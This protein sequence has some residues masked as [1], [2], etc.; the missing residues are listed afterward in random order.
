MAKG[1]ALARW[2]GVAAAA[3]ALLPGAAARAAPPAAGADARAALLAAIAAGAADATRRCRRF[4]A[5]DRAGRRRGV[6]GA[7]RH[8]A[9]GLVRQAEAFAAPA[10]AAAPEARVAPAPG[11]ARAEVGAGRVAQLL[12]RGVLGGGRLWLS[13][14]VAPAAEADV[15]EIYPPFRLELEAGAARA[16][17]VEAGSDAEFRAANAR[18]AEAQAAPRNRYQQQYLETTGRAGDLR[19]S[20]IPATRTAEMSSQIDAAEAND[21]CVGPASERAGTAEAC[22]GCPNAAACASGAG[23]A[24]P[25]DPTP[26]LVRDRLAGVKHVLL[27]LSGK[28]GVGKSTMSC[29]LALAPRGYDAGL[30]DIDICGPS[31][32]RMM[33]LRGRGVHQS[34]SGWSPVYVDSPGGELGVMSVG[35]M[36]PED[37]N[38]IIW[39]GPRKNGLI[40]QFLTEY[41]KLATPPGARRDDAQEVAMQDVRKELN[42]CAKT[43]IP[44]LGVVGNMCR[45]RVPLSSLEFVDRRTGRDATA[46]IRR[47]LREADPILKEV[48]DDV[49]ASVD[50]FACDD[51]AA[52]PAA[53]AAAFGVPYLGDVPLDPN[54]KTGWPHSGHSSSTV[55]RVDFFGPASASYSSSSAPRAHLGR[56]FGAVRVSTTTSARP[57]SAAR[58]R[59]VDGARA[60]DETRGAKGVDG[61]RGPRAPVRRDAPAKEQDASQLEQR[62]GSA[63]GSST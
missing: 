19:I 2:R 15:L 52:S 6:A 45:L 11:D 35:F 1:C 26:G 24:A 10:A 9:P 14:G 4:V 59:V 13:S 56:G 63:S 12:T 62:R 53:M 61:A 29:Q 34:S 58:R 38:A 22:E 23:R 27:V 5:E 47:L 60:R 44:V 55:A 8:L 50:V 49:D 57:L 32:P 54:S 43:R 37:D 20:T 31:V 41:L 40:K 33:G 7:R 25:E 28:G 18:T 36:L 17:L 51:A 21:G 46:E 30:L 39:R 3:A 42:F 16:T 48:F